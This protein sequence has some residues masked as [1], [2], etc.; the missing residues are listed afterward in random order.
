[1]KYLSTTLL[2]TVNQTRDSQIVAF[3]DPQSDLNVT[4][5]RQLIPNGYNSSENFT[6]NIPENKSGFKFI[7]HQSVDLNGNKA[8]SNVYQMKNNGTIIDIINNVD[9]QK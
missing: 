6:L 5:N 4:V 2:A 7:S 3:T 1:M 9:Y 8:Q